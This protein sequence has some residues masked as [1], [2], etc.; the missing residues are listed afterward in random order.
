LPL[1]CSFRC[2]LVS[3]LYSQCILVNF[4]LRCIQT[5]FENLN[6]VRKGSTAQETGAC[7]TASN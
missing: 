3:S 4:P 6:F 1:A 2:W 7:N 5:L